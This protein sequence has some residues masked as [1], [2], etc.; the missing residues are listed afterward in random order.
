V[1]VR[2]E[3]CAQRGGKTAAQKKQTERDSSNA[4]PKTF[5]EALNFLKLCVSVSFGASKA[6]GK[7]F[8]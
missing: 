7:L 3:D 4:T 5:L 2:A 8:I 1:D 6:Y